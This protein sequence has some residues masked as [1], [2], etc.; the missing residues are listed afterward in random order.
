MGQL[1]DKHASSLLVAALA[2]LRMGTLIG[3]PQGGSA[4]RLE[5]FAA[6]VPELFANDRV[7]WELVFQRL[8]RAGERDGLQDL[9]LVSHKH[10]HIAL[11][12][13][14]DPSIVLIAV[15]PRSPSIGL[16]MSEARARLS[17]LEAAY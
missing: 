4:E 2:D 5:S 16:I 17:Q 12:S 15:A 9:V 13:A 6:A 7:S 1:A 3:A 14:R 11:R 8:M 10:V